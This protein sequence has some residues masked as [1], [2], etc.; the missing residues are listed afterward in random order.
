[1]S[2]IMKSIPLTVFCIIITMP[3]TASAQDMSG[4]IEMLQRLEAKIDRVESGGRPQT[5][6]T[7]VLDAQLTNQPVVVE[8]FQMKIRQIEEEL[9]RLKDSTAATEEVS[10]KLA[11]IEEEVGK[12]KGL[13]D[14]NDEIQVLIRQLGDEVGRFETI[15]GSLASLQQQV[16]ELGSEIE[17]FRAREGTPSEQLPD[18]GFVDDLRDIIHGMEAVLVAASTAGEAARA[19]TPAQTTSRTPTLELGG[20]IKNGFSY[21]GSEPSDMSGFD[22]TNVRLK[23]TGKLH[24]NTSYGICLDAVRDDILLDAYIDHAVGHGLSLRIGQYKTPYGTDNLRA[25]HAIAFVTRPIIKSKVSPAFR[26]RGLQATYRH[27]YFDVIAA[28]MNGAG[29]NKADTNNNKSMAYRLVAKVMPGLQ[30]TGNY[31]TGRNDPADTI[32]DEFIDVGLNGMLGNWDYAAEFS[33]K[34][35]DAWT[36][37]AWYAFVGYDIRLD[38]SCVQF[39]TPALM[40]ESY[41]PDADT[42][43]DELGRYTIGLSLNFSPERYRNR[44]MLNYQINEDD[45]DVS[46]DDVIMLEYL[47]RF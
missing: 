31:Y 37:R 36:G 3:G 6:M 14:T 46:D 20:Y 39:I 8:Y 45:L 24:G 40:A 18:T 32:R 44:L 30:V 25:A 29:M 1:M 13:T 21:T 16:N 4:I 11:A 12:L 35:H 33:R 19:E 9:T 10:V 15:T 2:T 27:R 34:S 17:R 38:N 26:D 43:D 5:E 41:D 42:D 7:P 47:V 23:A 28:V 22:V